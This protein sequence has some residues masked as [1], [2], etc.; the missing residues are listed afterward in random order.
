MPW[1]KAESQLMF[2]PTF[3]ILGSKTENSP[4]NS[5]CPDECII[6]HRNDF[7]LR[8]DSSHSV[9]DLGNQGYSCMWAFPH[10]TQGS[11]S[12]GRLPKVLCILRTKAVVY[13]PSILLTCLQ[14]NGLHLDQSKH[15]NSE[16]A[17]EGKNGETTRTQIVTLFSKLYMQV[18]LK[19]MH[20]KESKK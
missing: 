5:R 1:W 2:P 16:A 12:S 3:Q 17:Q 19:H 7:L 9:D 18:W 8:D 15:W 20:W 6:Q 13:L 14:N 10:T 11:G 4:L